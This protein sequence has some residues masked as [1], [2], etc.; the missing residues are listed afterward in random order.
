MK[1]FFSPPINV[2]VR[3]DGERV[4]RKIEAIELEPVYLDTD[5]P[6]DDLVNSCSNRLVDENGERFSREVLAKHDLETG[7]REAGR[8][9]FSTRPQS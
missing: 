4:K 6:S 3:E 1:A 9:A 8:I 5:P 2:Y 7:I